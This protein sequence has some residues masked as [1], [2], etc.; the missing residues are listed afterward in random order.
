MLLGKALQGRR[1]DAVVA[2]KFFNPMGT[3]PNDSGMSRLHVMQAV[4]ASLRRLRMDH[5]D[6]QRNLVQLLQNPA[7]RQSIPDYI[8]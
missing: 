7:D 3:G 6:T 8:F 4:E 2:T 5:V 1:D